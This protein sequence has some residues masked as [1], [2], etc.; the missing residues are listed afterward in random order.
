MG[1]NPKIPQW[2]KMS[3][4]HI[5][6]QLWTEQ[7]VPPSGRVVHETFVAQQSKRLVSV[8]L[9]SLRG[10]QAI[11]TKARPEIEKVREVDQPWSLGASE[12]HEI[13]PEASSDLL[14]VWKIRLATGH[15]F[16]IREAKWVARL[17]DVVQDK[18]VLGFWAELYALREQTC[19]ILLIAPET[20]DLDA[21][22]VMTA[23][24]QET[25][26][27]VGMLEPVKFE[28]PYEKWIVTKDFLEPLQFGH[29]LSRLV[30]AMVEGVKGIQP[31]ES[32]ELSEE[33]EWVY[34]F[35]LEYLS[36][37]SKW[38]KLSLEKRCE[39]VLQLRDW[40]KNHPWAKRE[41]D[42][43]IWS[44]FDWETEESTEFTRLLKPTKLLKM[45]GYEVTKEPR[46]GT[47]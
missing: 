42:W 9:P 43:E 13:P 34:A 44:E 14:E 7:G 17:R 39:I 35:W 21:S 11:L 19:D 12:Q 3:I 4:I 33:A 5:Y 47:S 22:L 23:W 10:V 20:S 1:K 26:K 30:V 41:F 18:V 8:T 40:V 24:E 36:E 25:A 15:L 28:S 46:G 29:D 45:V 16:S 38:R 31:L 2:Q 32:L 27:A 6:N 37:G